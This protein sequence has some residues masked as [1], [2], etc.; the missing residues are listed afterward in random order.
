MDI[1][2]ELFRTRVRGEKSAFQTVID[3]AVNIAT[4]HR[5]PR[6]IEQYVWRNLETQERLYLSG[7]E[8]E[9]HGEV[10]QGAYMELARG[11]GVQEYRLLLV[12]AQA[13]Q[14][15]FRTASEF[16]KL[17]L[18]GS[19]FASSLL[20]HLLFAVHEAVATD[21]PSTALAYLKNERADYWSR[22]EDIV[23]LLKYFASA[24]SMA[25]LQHW[26]KDAQAASILSGLVL[27][28]YVGSR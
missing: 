12:D 18:S 2:H 4:N 26:W 28:D 20:R 17:G 13:N 22:K 25:N 8:I 14:A 23:T 9:R 21:N 10:R 24:S 3:R 6:G 5:M 19:S 11:F 27:N 16:G 15:R 7:L 1:K